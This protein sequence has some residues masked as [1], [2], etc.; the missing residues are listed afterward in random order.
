MKGLP[1]GGE[2]A[3]ARESNFFATAAAII[4]YVQPFNK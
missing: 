4:I 2:E 1:Y 3:F